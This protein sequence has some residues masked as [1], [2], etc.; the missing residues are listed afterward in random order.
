MLRFL[1]GAEEDGLE[2]FDSFHRFY[3]SP[4]I[5]KLEIRINQEKQIIASDLY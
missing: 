5:G 3:H 2:V 1:P 4:G